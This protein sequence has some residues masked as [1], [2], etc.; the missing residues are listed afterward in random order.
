MNDIFLQKEFT[1]KEYNNLKKQIEKYKNKST[2]EIIDKFLE[3][4][5]KSIKLKHQSL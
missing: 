4:Y 3:I 1:P 5:I 2:N